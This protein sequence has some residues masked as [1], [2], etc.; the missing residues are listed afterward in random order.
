MIF[1]VSKEAG[2]V[3]RELFAFETEQEAVEM[4]EAYN[5]VMSDDVGGFEWDL[6]IE[7]DE[8]YSNPDDYY[9]DC[10]MYSEA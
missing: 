6:V 1:I 10:Y 3:K 2:S 7:D 8:R 9:M 4:C 5:W